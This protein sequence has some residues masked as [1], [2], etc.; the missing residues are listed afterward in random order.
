MKAAVKAIFLILVFQIT[1]CWSQTNALAP[2]L[3][4]KPFFS[5]RDNVEKIYGQ[6][7]DPERNPYIVFYKHANLKILVSYSLGGCKE[8]E[9][10]L[11]DLPEWTVESI[12][13]KFS[14]NPPKLKD[15]IRNNKNFK[16]RINGDA[17]DHIEYYDEESGIIIC[18]ESYLKEVHRITLSPSRKDKQKFDCDNLK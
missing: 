13:Y 7:D 6:G 4:I 1:V 3:N 12:D 8:S 14:E 10:P 18:Y 11:Y 2:Y 17:T 15:L 16:K 5:T 9:Y